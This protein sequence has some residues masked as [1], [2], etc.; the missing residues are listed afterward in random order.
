MPEKLLYYCVKKI[1]RRS[2]ACRLIN[3]ASDLLGSN[4]DCFIN[5]IRIVIVTS[6]LDIWN[7]T[8]T[9]SITEMMK[10]DDATLNDIMYSLHSFVKISSDS[11]TKSIKI[12]LWIY[13]NRIDDDNILFRELIEHQLKH[14]RKDIII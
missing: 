10:Y 13:G 2:D 9:M 4:E 11:R 8:K 12:R 14:S 7:D 5:S 1:G 3:N 6:R